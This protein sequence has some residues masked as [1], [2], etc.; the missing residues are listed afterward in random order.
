MIR[1]LL[2]RTALA[3]LLTCAVAAVL[4]WR[5]GTSDTTAAAATASTLQGEYWYRLSL[6]DQPI[7]FYQSINSRDWRGD[8]SF[9]TRLRFALG[10][11]RPVTI[12]DRY[13]FAG[14]TLALRD[15]YH[16]ADRDGSMFTVEL[17]QDQAPGRWQARI[18]RNGDQTNTTLDEAVS[19]ADY[20]AVERWLN[21]E[22]TTAGARV[23]SVSLNLATLKIERDSYEL[24]QRDSRRAVLR[25][26]SLVEETEI[27]LDASLVPVRFRL[28]GVFD[29]ERV[30]RRIALAPVTPLAVA[31]FRAPLDQPLERHRY[32][33]RLKL[34]LA[35]SDDRGL[36]EQ[37]TLTSAPLLPPRDEDYLAASLDY[38][39]DHPRLQ[40]LLG[41]LRLPD[42]GEA[43]LRRLVAFVHG[44]LD[45]EERPDYRGVLTLLDD[46]RG[47]CTEF[48]DLLTALARA[49]GLPARTI[50]GMAYTEIQGPA[51]AFHAWNQVLVDGR[52][53]A[54]DP[55]WNQLRLDA[56]HWPL[57]EGDPTTLSLLTGATELS[58]KV[59]ATEYQAGTLPAS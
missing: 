1:S 36:P 23:R 56:T 33:S 22:N 28:A 20:L 35:S 32:L 18:D 47:D 3:F 21:D 30:E 14:A 12:S 40:T 54:V 44:F 37:V 31:S 2:L 51:F 34:E 52:W 7:G 49:A 5:L 15:A 53:R 13:R 4:V 38:P 10:S 39:S 48:A 26:P 57:P 55:T 46:R 16:R 6:T 27:E 58:L 8:Y 42:E 11:S 50:V 9:A 45:Y 43:K 19:L 41:S 59:L 24:V 25:H 17:V 29:L